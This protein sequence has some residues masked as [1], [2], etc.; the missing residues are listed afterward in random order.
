MKR[1][2]SIHFYLQTITSSVFVHISYAPNNKDY[3]KNYNYK[4]H[5]SQKIHERKNLN[6]SLIFCLLKV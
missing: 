6:S 5:Y 1:G 3:Q 4:N 2:L